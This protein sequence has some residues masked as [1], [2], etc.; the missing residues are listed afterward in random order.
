MLYFSVD[1]L[2]RILKFVHE[3]GSKLQN[4][5][6]QAAKAYHLLESKIVLSSEGVTKQN[7][8]RICLVSLP[9]NV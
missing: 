5:R 7:T 9:S 8:S 4:S 3:I 6:S 2:L 1:K